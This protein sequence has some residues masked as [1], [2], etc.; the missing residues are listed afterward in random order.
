M[1]IPN[2]FF[3]STSSPQSTVHTCPQWGTVPFRINIPHLPQTPPP[4]IA[5]LLCQP[6]W[7][8]IPHLDSTH[9]L[10]FNPLTWFLGSKEFAKDIASHVSLECWLLGPKPSGSYPS[11]WKG[12]GSWTYFLHQTR[13]LCASFWLPCVIELELFWRS[14]W[15]SEPMYRSAF[16]I[17]A[18]TDRKK[19]SAN[20]AKKIS[21]SPLAQA[22]LFTHYFS[23]FSRLSLCEH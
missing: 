14:K 20:R 3:K 6:L 8:P 22:V 19:I 2:W 1:S 23:P 15:K 11:H 13:M 7:C 17:L 12:S 21:A 18:H 5:P 9:T 4:T 16:K 10:C